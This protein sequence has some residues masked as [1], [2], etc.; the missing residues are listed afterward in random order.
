[1]TGIRRM[2]AVAA[3]LWLSTI[4]WT[5]GAG[6]MTMEETV[7]GGKVA[8]RA[9]MEQGEMVN[10]PEGYAY[11][12]YA[13]N[14]TTVTEKYYTADGM[15]FRMPGG[16][17][18]RALTYG[19]RHR[20]AE[21]T[22]LDETG[23]RTENAAGYARV[24]IGYTAKGQI[25]NV[26]YYN[27]DN[28]PVLVPS[29]GYASL[30]NDYRGTTLTQTS[31]L[32]EEKRSVNIPE[33]YATMIQR[34][35]KNN[36]IVEIRFEDAGENAAS[37]TA[38]WSDCKRKLDAKGR[39]VSASFLDAQGM[40]VNT[41]GGYA[42]EE[43]EWESDSS[44]ILR[45]FDMHG[46]AVPVN[47]EAV[48]LRREMDR[49]GRIVRETCMDGNGQPAMNRYQVCTTAYAYDD[50]GRISR[51]SLQD[52]RGNP[53]AGSEGWAEYRDSLND[54]GLLLERV[55]AGE[56]GNALNTRMGYSLIRY[57]YD[58]AGRVERIEYLDV[59]GNPVQP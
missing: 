7:K 8:R 50:L 41:A 43:L 1:M 49:E 18:S 12:T 45:R 2:A 26:N 56:D 11:I 22:Y 19:N 59:N 38:G 46:N 32:D 9:W 10:G 29:V 6:A 37:C 54:N 48:A 25:T 57:T 33:G 47:G 28:Q 21:I 23:N 51:V 35:N 42:L 3:A 4:L 15:P 13:Y 34:V 5:A 52:E 17:H 39:I 14:D 27:A 55:Y 16:Y 44:F 36:Q 24:R 40:P 30:K 20:L 58:T 53:A 31:Y